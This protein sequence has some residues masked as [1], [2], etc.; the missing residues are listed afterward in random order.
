MRRMG[1]NQPKEKQGHQRLVVPE[2]KASSH[3]REQKERPTPGPL[4]T[5]LS[6]QAREEL[7]QQNEARHD[8][9]EQ[10]GAQDRQHT[11]RCYQ[12]LAD[13]RASAKYGSNPYSRKPK[14]GTA[15]GAS[16]YDGSG[17]ST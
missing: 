6:P 2:E 7:S 15:C 11:S 5:S 12:R 3:A 9:I 10:L 1:N 4:A 13:L 17:A 14:T 16:V 8:W